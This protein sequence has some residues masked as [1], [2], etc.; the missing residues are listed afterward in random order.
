M[1]RFGLIHLDEG[2]SGN[3]EKHMNN[4]FL[5]HHESNQNCKPN[6]HSMIYCEILSLIQLCFQKYNQNIN[7]NTVVPVIE[8]HSKIKQFMVSNDIGE[9]FALTM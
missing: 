8:K 5:Q 9:S 6:F 2:L 4:A 3:K 1:C 7:T